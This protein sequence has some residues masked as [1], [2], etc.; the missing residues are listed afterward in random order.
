MRAVVQVPASRTAVAR[1]PRRRSQVQLPGGADALGDAG[2]AAPNCRAPTRCRRPSNGGSTCRRPTAPA[3][4]P[5]Q[6]VRVRFGGAA[7]ATAAAPA[8]RLTVPAAA[9]LRRGELTAVY[10]AREQRLRASSAVRL[11]AD[12]QA[13]GVEV[14][15]GLKAGERIALDPVRAGLAGADAGRRQVSAS[16]NDA[17]VRIATRRRPRWAFPAAWRAPSRPT[18]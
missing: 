16:P 8:G 7:A 15:A 17:A 3:L 4:Q 13:A 10:V 12:A 9:V 11:G 5:G 2:D 1:V 18:R 6:S 14:L